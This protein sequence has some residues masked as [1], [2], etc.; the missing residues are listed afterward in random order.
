MGSIILKNKIIIIKKKFH[1]WSWMCPLSFL[2]AQR[3]VIFLMRHVVIVLNAIW[4]FLLIIFC[5]IFMIDAFN[6]HPL[7]VVRRPTRLSCSVCSVPSGWWPLQLFS[8]FPNE[9][10]FV[11]EML[12]RIRRKMYDVF[13]RR[14]AW[15]SCW[16]LCINF[17]GLASRFISFFLY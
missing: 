2:V 6:S 9:L 1:L 11:W 3:L 17:T 4:S 8:F 5:A 13:L 15:L 7:V 16:K 14:G 10:Q 12:G